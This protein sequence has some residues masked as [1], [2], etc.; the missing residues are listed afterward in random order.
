VFA[1]QVD[2]FEGAGVAA[3]VSSVLQGIHSTIFAYGQTGSG[4]TYT[5]DCPA[6]IPDTDCSSRCDSFLPAQY[7]YSAIPNGGNDSTKHGAGFKR[8]TSSSVGGVEGDI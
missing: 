7:I 2:V 5:M 3:L 6:G 8:Q 1:A 4:K